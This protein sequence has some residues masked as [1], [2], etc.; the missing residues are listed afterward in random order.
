MS[1]APALEGARDVHDDGGPSSQRF[2]LCREGR[3]FFASVSWT[4]AARATRCGAAEVHPRH[5]MRQAQL[6]F[7]P[8][9]PQR[10]MGSR[11]PRSTAP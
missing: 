7:S 6:P 10:H 11:G 2:L 9:W 4:W 5:L 8:Q 1:D 3:F